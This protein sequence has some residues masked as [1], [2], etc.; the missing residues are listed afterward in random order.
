M[1]DTEMGGTDSASEPSFSSPPSSQGSE[2]VDEYINNELR[3]K[4]KEFKKEAEEGRK[5]GR[6][7]QERPG[8]VELSNSHGRLTSPSSVSQ[9]GYL[10]DRSEP[11]TLRTRSASSEGPATSSFSRGPT[12]PPRLSPSDSQKLECSQCCTQKFQELLRLQF[13]QGIISV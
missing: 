3:R 7:V 6:E 9:R 10:L 2:Y 12:F 1:R 4:S 5:K 11:D 13:F 8:Q